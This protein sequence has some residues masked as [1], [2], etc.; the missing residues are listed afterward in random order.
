SGLH[1]VA[2]LN[3]VDSEQV[4]REA[5]SRGVEVTPLSDYFLNAGRPF[6]GRRR[7]AESAALHDIHQNALVLGFAAVRPDE[8]RRGMDQLAAAI[9][10][11]PRVT[12]EKVLP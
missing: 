5:A 9:H 12:R 11:T 2:D 3:G 4:F 8:M 1:A 6:Q 7:G 10:A